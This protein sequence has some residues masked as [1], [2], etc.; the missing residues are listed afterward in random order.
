MKRNQR[1]P[2]STVGESVGAADIEAPAGLRY[3]TSML[4]EHFLAVPLR[5]SA[6]AHSDRF[7]QDAFV[8]R[9]EVALR[10]PAAHSDRFRR[11]A[12]VAPDEVALG[13]PGK[14]R[15]SEMPTPRKTLRSTTR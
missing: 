1:S 5:E 9:D 11:E 12:I 14:V 10:E 6:A 7:G 4:E 2:T 8:A 3:A 15:T 13:G